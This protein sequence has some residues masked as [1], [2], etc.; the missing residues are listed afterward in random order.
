MTNVCP[1]DS[2]T[3]HIDIAYDGWDRISEVRVCEGAPDPAS[4]SVDSYAYDDASRLVAWRYQEGLSTLRDVSY[5]HDSAGNIERVI[6]G[7]SAT[8]YAYDADNRLVSATDGQRTVTYGNDELGRR[9]SESSGVS[10]T[11]YGWDATGHL[12][13]VVSSD[14]TVTYSY[15]AGGMR[16][17]TVRESEGGTETIEH[18]WR[19]ATL[20]AERFS[21]GTV[22]E[23]VYGPGGL[24]L[25]LVVRAPGQSAGCTASR[26]LDT[27]GPK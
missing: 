24:P 16:E 9:T 21:D 2:D 26:F 5:E 1:I 20:T 12:A 6:D 25:E 17:L 23:Y 27:S 18:F 19:G 13:A 8:T 15:G 22:F 10:T 3:R 7:G 11:T 4:D 14:T